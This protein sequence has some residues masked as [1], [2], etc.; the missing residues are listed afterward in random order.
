MLVLDEACLLMV[1]RLPVTLLANTLAVFNM[2]QVL[3]QLVPHGEL[4]GVSF[5]RNVKVVCTSKSLRFFGCL[6]VIIGSKLKI[7]LR[8]S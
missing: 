2:G 3:Q 4:P 8:C 5:A 7:T 1:Y 6:K